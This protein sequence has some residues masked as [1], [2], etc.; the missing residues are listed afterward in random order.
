MQCRLKIRGVQ[1]QDTF[2]PVYQ[3][4]VEILDKLLVFNLHL[5]GPG[6]FSAG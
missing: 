2:F 5:P 6:A 4:L 3:L 1:Y